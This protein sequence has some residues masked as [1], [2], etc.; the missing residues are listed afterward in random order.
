VREREKERG[1][2][3]RER[4]RREKLSDKNILS[5]KKKYMGLCTIDHIN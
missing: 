2:R 4:E 3:K 1:E 5:F